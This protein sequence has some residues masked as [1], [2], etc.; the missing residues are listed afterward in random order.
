VGGRQ[1]EVGDRR[2]GEN[3]M[4]MGMVVG[5]GMKWLVEFVTVVLPK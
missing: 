2:L 3:R 4:H 5:G 1:R